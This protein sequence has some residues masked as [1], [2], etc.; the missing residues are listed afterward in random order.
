MPFTPVHIIVPP[1]AREDVTIF[2]TYI[3]QRY[4]VPHDGHP[5]KEKYLGF[6]DHVG[7]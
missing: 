7:V 3:E 6:W 2:D 5:M 1:Q 4:H